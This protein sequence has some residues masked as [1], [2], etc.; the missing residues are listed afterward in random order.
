MSEL[1]TKKHSLAHIMA[2]AVKE[3]F[4]NAKLGIGP[5][6]EDGF[7][8]DFDFGEDILTDADLK[9]IEKSMKKIISQ[10]Q[11]FI[12]FYVN[13]DEARNIL[14]EM[15][16][17]FKNVLIDRF[18]SGDFKNKEKLES[19]KVGFSINTSKGKNSDYY[20]KLQSF[21]KEKGFYDFSEMDG[22]QVKN[23]KFLDMCAGPHIHNS[24]EID[25]N[26]FKLAKIAGAYWLGDAENKQLTRIYAYAFETAE[27]LEKHLKMLEEAK[28]RDHRIIG[29]KLKLFTI[30]ELVGPG[31]PLMQPAGMVIRKEIE[32]YLW[33]LHKDK[34][35]LRVWTPHLAKEALYEC[36]G[37]AGHYLEDMFKVFG[38]TS[39]ED[40]F[41]KP[42]NCPHHMQLFADN[43]FSYRDMPIRYF[44]PATVYRDEKSGQLSGLTRVRAITQD[45]GHLFCRVSQ[46]KDEVKTIT[47]IIKSFYTTMGMTD[48]YWVSLSVRGN[49]KTYLGSDEVWEMAETAL[50][51]A[52]Q[53]N[54]LPYK[55]IEGEA[56]FYGPKLDFMFKDAIGREWQLATIQCD[57]NL[58]ERFKLEFT[59]EKGEKERPVVIHRAISGSLERAMGVLIEHFAGIFPLWMAPRQ[60]IIIPVV[61][62]FDDYAAKVEKTLKETGIRV[63]A[64][65]ST[66]GLNKKVR[67]AEKM[68]NNYI[69]VLGEEEE[70]SG[71]VSVRNYKTK[72]QT[73]EKLADFISKITEEIRTR[74]L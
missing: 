15:D 53:E 74:S 16:E 13:Y 24:L 55:R 69:L 28:K 9:K 30:S 63:S 68:H 21:L 58:P 51:E 27:E 45:D 7:Y 41:L 42:M 67:N 73:S 40:F 46:I 22:D 1:S 60:V 18:E 49:D 70:K 8:Y 38:G 56:A 2:Q 61:P 29:Q 50:E 26:S 57:F 64:D 48:G 5:A 72:E 4:P 34:G 47:N 65:Y 23:L 20:A 31:L 39:K 54:N 71:T 44:E 19:G 12:H 32:D 3:Y 66:D 10:K 43:Q 36:S 6:T 37:H 17:E 25:P 62:K 33:E 35:Y 11:E 14:K 59:N 52:S